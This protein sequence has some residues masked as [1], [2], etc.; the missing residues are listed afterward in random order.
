M[1]K[2]TL[3]DAN[4]AL[5]LVKRIV[6]DLVD[7]VRELDSLAEIA[8]AKKQQNKPDEARTVLQQV[9]SR[10]PALRALEDELRELGIQ[11]KDHRTGLIDFPAELQGEDV[12][13]CW[14]LGENRIDHWHDL[15]SGFAGRKPTAGHFE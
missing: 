9:E 7:Q 6:R 2:W 11:L 8:E 5:P 3:T 1:K 15:E 4:R 10:M 12:L 13:L 14:K